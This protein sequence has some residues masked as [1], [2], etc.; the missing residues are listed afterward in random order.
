MSTHY[1]TLSTSSLKHAAAPPIVW[2]D[3]PDVP[4]DVTLDDEWDDSAP[5]WTISRPETRE[6]VIMALEARRHGVCGREWRNLITTY[7][8][9]LES[10][11]ERAFCH[12]MLKKLS[13]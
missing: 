4:V 3:L 9:T 12:S 11:P 5:A 1:L 10:E 6:I 7:A 8:S 2:I 13:L